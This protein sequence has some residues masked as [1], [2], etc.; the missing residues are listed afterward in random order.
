MIMISRRF[1]FLLTLLL[2]S[3]LAIAADKVIDGGT[4]TDTVTISDSGID[5]LHSFPSRNMDA[6]ETTLTLI[7]T[8]NNTLT[9]A[10]I[11]D[12]TSD[13]DPTSFITAGSSSYIFSD[14][15][16]DT[17]S[18]YYGRAKC[19]MHAHDYGGTRGVA[20]DR[21]N[22]IAVTYGPGS[23]NNKCSVL[24]TSNWQ[25]SND[26][27]P[28]PLR[29][30]Y[31]STPLTIYGHSQTDYIRATLGA[32][33]IYAMGGNDQVAGKDGADVIDL[34]DGDD[35][36]FVIL[37]D[38]TEDTLIGG[39][40][41]DT[42]SFSRIRGT[43]GKNYAESY[44]NMNHNWNHDFAVTAHLGDLLSDSSKN[45]S[46]FEN[47]V[48]TGGSDTLTGDNNN[49][50]IVGGYSSDVLT[51]LAGNDT[52]YD[53]INTPTNSEDDFG[54]ADIY[55]QSIQSPGN[56]T[57]YTYGDDTLY[58]G[59]GDDVLIAS[60]GEDT[61]DGGAG[62][63]TL[64]GGA[65]ADT[66]VIREGDGGEL[67]AEADTITD[68]TDGTD[69]IGIDGI[70]YND[71]TRE[72]SGS[73]VL[74]KYNDK[75]LTKVSNIGLANLDYYDI[76]STSTAVQTVS[77]T[78][79]DDI[80]LG[81][82]GNDTFVTDAGA[83]VI[84]GYAGNDGITLDGAGD[85]TID[86]G[87]GTDTVTISDSGI[88]GLHSFPSRNMDAS[89]TTLTL[90]DTNNNTLTLANIIDFTSDSDP[91]SFITAGSSS[92][93]FS[94][95]PTDT[96]SSYYGRAKCSMHAHDY[97][98]TRGV[99]VDRS[100]DIAVTYGPGSP[101]NKC[102]VLFTSNWQESN[103]LSPHPLRKDYSSTP[104]T[105]Y[106]HSQTD[107]IRA[108]LGADTI[109]AMGGNDQ[110]AGKDGADV[111]DLGDG[112]DVAFVILSDLTEDTLIGGIGTDTLSFSR[113]RGTGGKNYA[114]SYENM[115][116]NWNHDF[117]VTA[118]L[119][120]L[121]SDSSKNISGFENLVGTGGSDTLTGDN[122][123]NVIVGGYSSDVLTGLAGNDTIYDDI[124][125]PTNSEDDFGSAD[126]YGQSIQSPGNWTDYTYGDD[127]LYGGAGDD[128]LIA[129][130]GEDTLDGGAGADTLT[131]GAGADT[132]VIREGDG[133]ELIAEADTI[134]DF[135]N[136]TDLIGMSGLNYKELMIEQ[137]MGSYS[138]HVVVKKASSG[139]CLTI[140]QNVSLGSVD[141]KDFQ[142]I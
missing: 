51:G 89:E 71:I 68:F 7:D 123:N 100:N 70:K 130:V 116:H 102:S 134:T 87:T 74:I 69:L 121:L 50:V 13:S 11:I 125:T 114:E 60:V 2:A 97:G 8:N 49:N 48:G 86:G 72:V 66:F 62:A 24:F 106:G 85:K 82:S 26:L 104:L 122:N 54:S 28:H 56:W 95:F 126:I 58:G 107:Y 27:S 98:G 39:I 133:G 93:I 142:A 43:G 99:A 47:L 33:T 105:I 20:V 65:G 119:G 64:T 1:K 79:G 63:D 55:G 88:D 52:I 127:T 21:S 109:Y 3:N 112:D 124:N 80:L 5:G 41:T 117:A 34:G 17:G 81:G 37:S 53:D 108:T 90:I 31:S 136:G 29:K 19:S 75:I 4:G 25:E 12:F 45:I 113:I 42:L 57:D 44:E 115:N 32:D 118:H 30:D 23:P 101:N 46:G 141:D 6:S 111:I 135:T 16:T 35:V 129:S 96:G 76:V 132:F 59:A 22:D 92:Y 138:S 10:N 67:I 137:G 83:D 120:D 139:E 18:S 73:D 15:P 128:V 94:D 77:G 140:I 103:D 14:F 110:V 61:L 78:S 91:T 40:G 38:L 131:G 36:A 9:L 84:L